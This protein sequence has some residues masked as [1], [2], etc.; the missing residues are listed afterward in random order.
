MKKSYSKKIRKQAKCLRE[1]GESIGEIARLLSLSKSTVYEWTKNLER[2]KEYAQLGRQRWLEKIQPL[3]ALAQKHKREKKVDTIQKNIQLE[4]GNSPISIMTKK[5]MLSCL[6][7][8][9]GSKGRGSLIFTNTDPRLMKLFVTLLRECYQLDEQKFRVKLYL[10]W[11]HQ[12]SKTMQFW[13]KLLE[14]PKQQFTKTYWKKRSETKRFRRNVG[15]I[16]FLKYNSDYLREEI[17]QY[18]YALHGKVV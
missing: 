13:S 8:S 7:W 15:G 18:A 2:A 16:C 5:A 14:I 10:H 1:Q 12:E 11:Y 17:L 6:Y 3:G 9:E 4:L